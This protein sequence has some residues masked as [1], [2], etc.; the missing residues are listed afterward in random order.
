MN[1]DILSELPR[2]AWPIAEGAGTGSPAPRRYDEMLAP[3][4]RARTHWGPLIRSVLDMGADA[5]HEQWRSTQRRMRENGVSYNVTADSADTA[6]PW[7]LDLLPMI[8]PADEWTHIE[9]AVQQRAT[10]L[11]SV[12]NDL[13]G[14]QRLVRNGLLPASLLFNHEGFLRPCHGIDMAQHRFMHLYAADLA[15][16]P[17]G[18]WWV[19]ADRTQAP[20]GIGYAVENRLAISRAFEPVLSSM[21]V[22]PLSP[23]L[24]TMRESLVARAPRTSAVD[25]ER[26][27]GRKV[28]R[29]AD[30][31]PLIVLLTPGPYN[32]TY[33]E[34]A[35]LARYLGFPL[36]V[37]SDLT[38][39]HGFVWL[40]T[41][42]GL[43]R[44]HAIVRRVDDDFCDPLFLRG[45][46]MLGVAGLVDA[47]RRN[48]V[49]VANGLGS[50]LVESGAMLG[51]LP[52]ISRRLLG[53]DLRMP[54]V[55]TWW[56]GEPAAL[57]D[58]ISRLDRLVFKPAWPQLRLRPVFGED[59]RGEQ[60]DAFVA[61]LRR[62]PEQW[63]AQESVRLSRAPVWRD[64]ITPG[65]VPATPPHLDAAP[66]SM[67]VYACVRPDGQGWAVMPGAL[68]RVATG[69]DDRVVSMQFGGSSK[70]TWVLQGEA[71]TP[72]ES[73][74]VGEVE[75]S[76][77]IRLV[78]GD[79]RLASR[80]VENLYWFGRYA[81]RCDNMARLL[82]R[83]LYL[84]LT[85]ED[86]SAPDEWDAIVEVARWYMLVDDEIDATDPSLREQLLAAVTDRTRVGFAAN[87]RRLHDV[88][89][90]LHERL[91][92]DNWRTI[93]QM[94][95]R[96]ARQHGQVSVQSALQLLDDATVSMMTLT[97]FAIDGMTRDMGWR[98][99]SIG[100][101]IERAQGLAT[102]LDRM[103]GRGEGIRLD[104][105]LELCDSIATYRSRYIARP[106]W[107]P[108]LDLLVSD[109][110][111]PRSIVFQLDGTIS[112]LERI[113]V[114][115]DGRAAAMLEPMVLAFR[116][117]DPPALH[118]GSE[119]LRLRL[120]ELVTRTSELS[121]YLC[122]RFFSLS[123]LQELS[124]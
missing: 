98:F 57:N 74:A 26:A 27:L 17:D 91:S 31:S 70:D 96:L 1:E 65:Q 67:R 35:F 46:S 118:H 41:L 19:L 110:T 113:A 94:S 105:L 30:D 109:E 121:D 102:V 13:Y 53:E 89:T 60:R 39:R 9:A 40:K 56:C 124:R 72:V 115:D 66:I 36:V 22:R 78:R 38:V 64:D 55:A 11:D 23:F 81:E 71:R 88:A 32:E 52:A 107:M 21:D 37:G 47:V 51:F 14:E 75:R 45:D 24:M 100:R 25:A 6:R 59:L 106:Q 79:E 16:S 7:D 34:Q 103:L 101:R 104:G 95:L 116:R 63:V 50:S 90:R 5:L 73:A 54:S 48:N 120:D 12:L 82:R 83:A 28:Q 76:R 4:G 15:R 18:R 68:T 58:A 119:V 43:Q 3:E 77:P 8:V 92:L 111:N 117:L 20:S 112:H 97:G 2:A 62:H 108:V 61:T 114:L 10:V 123:S 87:L 49:M 86:A 80:S 42:G 85:G 33:S 44:V 93:N 29:G 84:R 69:P 99:M 122:Q